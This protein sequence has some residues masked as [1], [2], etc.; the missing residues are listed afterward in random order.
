MGIPTKISDVYTGFVEIG[1]RESRRSGIQI[2]IGQLYTVI[3][4]FTS[5]SQLCTHL[6]KQRYYHFS[7]YKCIHTAGRSTMQVMVRF[8]N[9][10][11]RC[12]SSLLGGA[13]VLKQLQRAR[14]YAKMANLPPTIS[15]AP[16]GAMNS[17]MKPGVF[18]AVPRA[19]GSLLKNINRTKPPHASPPG[20]NEAPRAVGQNTR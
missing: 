14:R 7:V 1:G 6:N 11:C 10:S 8:C 20:S 12:M 16:E 3:R 4:C 13:P 2:V 17:D 18:P 9:R 15:Q 19:A 5:A